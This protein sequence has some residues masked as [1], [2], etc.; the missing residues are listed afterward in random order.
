MALCRV[1]KR[2]RRAERTRLRCVSLFLVVGFE[3]LLMYLFVCSA[4]YS[5]FDSGEVA[6]LGRKKNSPFA[7]IGM[8]PTSCFL[9]SCSTPTLLSQA[10]LYLSQ[11]TDPT[12]RYKESRIERKWN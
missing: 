9:K 4:G 12:T 5:F 7:D 1:E 3:N 11:N 6:L 2:V 8:F 10:K